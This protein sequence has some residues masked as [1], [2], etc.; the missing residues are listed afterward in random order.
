MAVTLTLVEQGSNRLRYLVNSN[1]TGN[2]TAS[3]TTTGAATP[4]LLTDSTFVGPGPSP[5]HAIAR[6][7]QDG[8]GILPAGAFTQA[9]ARAMWMAD[10]SDT[11]LGNNKVARALPRLTPRS[12]AALWLV[13]A[14]VDGSGHPV[15]NVTASD[16][17]TAYL[18]VETQGAIGI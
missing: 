15:I 5:I 4:D 2:T 18:D 17:G 12:G 8:L 7:F 10:T 13:D 11:I 6:A 9:Q 14:N 16:V 1:A 3:L